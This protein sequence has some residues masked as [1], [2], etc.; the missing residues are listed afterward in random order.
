[1]K[2]QST[3]LTDLE[4]A[5]QSL[6]VQ[7]NPTLAPTK[8]DN[9]KRKCSCMGT[10]HALLTAAPNCLNCGKIICVKEGLGP[11]TFCNSPLLSHDEILSMIRFLKDERGKEKMAANNSSH[12]R[13]EVSKAPRPFSG[14]HNPSPGSSQPVSES[15]SDKLAAAERHR[16]KL[17]AFQSQN[18]RRTRVHDEAA[19]F[20]T[21][22]AGQSMWASPEDRARQLKRQ[23][24]ALREQEW[25][26]RPEWEKR[27]I[28]ASIDLAGGKVVRKF[29]KSK[30][31]Q[32]P[33]SSGEDEGPLISVP[34]PEQ[35]GGF[36][37]NPLLG[38]L[39]R[40]LA[41]VDLAAEGSTSKLAERWRRVQDDTDDN[42]RWILDGALAASN[43]DGEREEPA[44]CG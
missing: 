34:A 25:N 5:I 19:D 42:E 2:G 29:E 28:V 37:R 26:A 36:G 18:A 16:D 33:E 4:Y 40:P 17:L 11:C 31:P 1:M 32:T 43:I 39:I 6:E 20:E 41:K 13:A 15:E 21:P 38:A 9:S 44:N 24:K 22:D 30:R 10:R 12:K 27:R 7:T 8:E 35:H 23:Q 14:S 3:A